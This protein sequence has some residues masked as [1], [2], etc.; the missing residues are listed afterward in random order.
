MSGFSPSWLALREPADH[1]ARDPELEDLV[2]GRL[3][4]RDNAMVLDLGCGSGSNLRALAPALPDHQFWRLVDHDAALLEAAR[5]RLESWADASE[6]KSGGDLH[7]QKGEKHIRVAFEQADLRSGVA[8]L[9]SPTPDLVTAAAL[10]DLVS[11]SWM[12]G[13]ARDL[14]ACGAPLYAVLTY[15]GREIWRPEHPL[16]ERILAAFHRHQG[17]DKGFGPAA[18]PG[19]VAALAAAFGRVG[20][21]VA[22]ADSAW[23]LGPQQSELI[24][25]LA[26]GIAQAAVE[27]GDVTPGEAQGWAQARAGASRVLVGHEDLFAT[28]PR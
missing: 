25:E 28:P 12:D 13:F 7:L 1:D 26:A 2:A 5:D 10:F 9:L 20:Y 18:G 22:T 16:D 14:A 8:A 17:R 6:R 23:V 21:A 15:D 27:T 19:S 4:E 3:G 11:A 24:R